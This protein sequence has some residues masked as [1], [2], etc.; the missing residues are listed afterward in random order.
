MKMK[1][2]LHWWLKERKWKVK[3][4][5]NWFKPSYSENL[6]I[7]LPKNMPKNQWVHVTASLDDMKFSGP[8][9]RYHKT[10]MWSARAKIDYSPLEQE[11]WDSINK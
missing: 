9:G 8:F 11:F 5:L 7:T 6:I 4:F 2:R 1:E 10:A 3:R